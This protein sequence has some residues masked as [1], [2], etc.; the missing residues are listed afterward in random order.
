MRAV[1]I[2]FVLSLFLFPFLFAHLTSI[3]VLLLISVLSS[4]CLFA[5]LFSF[6]L[7]HRLRKKSE[8]LDELEERLERLESGTAS[9]PDAPAAREDDAGPAQKD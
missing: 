5:V 8:Q 2:V 9:A 3:D 6:V 4:V 1:I 7:F